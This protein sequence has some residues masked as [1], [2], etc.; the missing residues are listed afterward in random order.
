MYTSR[1]DTT[2]RDEHLCGGGIGDSSGKFDM[3][4]LSS[5]VHQR[6]EEQLQEYSAEVSRREVEGGPT[7]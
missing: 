5:N 3:G 2:N 7:S 6:S 1:Y 4:N